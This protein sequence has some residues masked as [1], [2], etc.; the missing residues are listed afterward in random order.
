MAWRDLASLEGVFCE[1]ASA[2]SLAALRRARPARDAVAVCILTGHGLKDAA[3]VD[4]GS[5][6]VVEPSLDAILEVLA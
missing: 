1:P 2:A 4:E 5:P 3:A 6:V